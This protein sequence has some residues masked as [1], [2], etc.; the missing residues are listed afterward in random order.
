MPSHEYY[1]WRAIDLGY[2]AESR[3]V[4][5]NPRV[6]AVLVC[7]DRVIGEGYHRCM[8]G[9][10]A[11]VHCL[12]S[13]S[14]ADRP[15]IPESTLYVTLEPCAHEGLTPSC[16]RRLVSERV[17]HVVVGTMDPNPLVAGKGVAILREAGVSVEVGCLESQCRELAKV[18]LTNQ[19]LH[20]P[21]VLLKWAES[22][23]GFV[24]RFRSDDTTPP[25]RLSTPYTQLLVHRLRSQYGAILVGGH[26]FCLDRPSLT[27]RLWPP[28]HYSPLRILLSSQISAPTGWVALG[29]LSAEALASLLTRENIPSLMVEG[30]PQVL[31]SFIDLGLWDEARVETA[32][33]LLHDGVSAPRL[34]ET[35][36]P[37][38]V[39]TFGPNRITLYRP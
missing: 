39:R 26:T 32:P 25:A 9:P 38:S 6:G 18:F 1:M 11:E 20:R 24:D 15:L 16:A 7:A 34:P 21:Y 14:S 13:V 19:K 33:T 5:L 29:S 8:G 30:G 27:N 10:H 36:R 37:I 35:A 31:Q 12:N 2:R 22:A 3:E 23:D 4:R 17:G 28:S